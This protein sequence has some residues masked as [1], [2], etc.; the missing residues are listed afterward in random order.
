M[1]RLTLHFDRPG[2][3][4]GSSPRFSFISVSLVSQTRV[5]MRL[6]CEVINKSTLVSSMFSAYSFGDPSL[7]LKKHFGKDKEPTINF[8]VIQI[9]E[10]GGF[11]SHR[12]IGFGLCDM[13]TIHHANLGIFSN[14]N[15]SDQ[16]FKLLIF[17]PF[18]GAMLDVQSVSC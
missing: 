14:L 4:S 17:N 10:R 8:S 15:F 16:I 5:C 1:H 9:L 11:S 3:Q 6:S 12:K 2:F 7:R 13:L 18:S